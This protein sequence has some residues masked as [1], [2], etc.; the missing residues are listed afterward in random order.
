MK[1]NLKFALSHNPESEMSP[2]WINIPPSTWTFDIYFSLTSQIFTT[3]PEPLV[4]SVFVFTVQHCSLHN[5]C[6]SFANNLPCLHRWRVS[7][8]GPCV[9]A[10]SAPRTNNN[11]QTTTAPTAT[12]ATAPSTKWVTAC[13]L[14]FLQTLSLSV[15]FSQHFLLTAASSRSWLLNALWC[16]I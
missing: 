4:Y 16:R 14:R 12:A 15:S 2:R 3:L 13:L 10:S 7:G 8:H 5:R 1:F 6:L 9:A 11:I